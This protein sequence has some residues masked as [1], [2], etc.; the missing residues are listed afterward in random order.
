[1]RWLSAV[2]C[3]LVACASAG[4]DNPG[5]PD[6]NKGTDGPPTG[7]GMTPDAAA[8]P[9]AAVMMTLSQTTSNMN[10]ASNSVTCNA[11]EDSWYR[12]FPLADFG[13][14]GGF[15]VQSVTFGAQEALGSPV[16]QVKIGTYS[17]TPGT[18]IST[19]NITPINSTTVTIPNQTN[20]GTNIVAPITGVIPANGQLVV[21]L[22]KP[23][24]NT[25]TVYF[26][27]GASNSGETKP[28]YFR[29]PSC[30]Y[31]NVSIATP[32]TPGSIGVPTAQLNIT[33]TGVR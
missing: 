6:G 31:Q 10:I 7:D 25:S 11:G 3:A 26:Y 24:M 29:A 23:G 33:V 22:F 13:I 32:T 2:A 20:P 17:G 30:L 28:G 14:T 12:V 1:M 19:A 8:G 18:T 5:N 9:D 27:V 21:E 16:V 15:N 4:T